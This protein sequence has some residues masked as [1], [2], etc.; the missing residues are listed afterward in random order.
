[1]QERI[2]IGYTRS[3][4]GISIIGVGITMPTNLLPQKEV[5]SCT[6]YSFNFPNVQLRNTEA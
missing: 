1:M 2:Q 3:S 6:I 5:Q 4:R